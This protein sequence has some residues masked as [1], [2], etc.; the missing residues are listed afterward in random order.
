M[1]PTAAQARVW[2]DGSFVLGKIVQHRRHKPKIRARNNS[3]RLGNRKVRN[4]KITWVDDVKRER[5][6]PAKL[7]FLAA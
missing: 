3:I 2:R 6:F 5:S 1:A 4:L 7:P